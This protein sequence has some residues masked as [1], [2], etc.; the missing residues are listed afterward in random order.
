[1]RRTRAALIVLVLL[2]SL[3]AVGGQAASR[4]DSEQSATIGRFYMAD[5]SLQALHDEIE[6]DPMGIGYKNGDGTWKEDAVI[7]GLINDPANGATITRKLIER[8]EIIYSIE[9]SE[10]IQ[11]G[12]DT[13]PDGVFSDSERW[14]LS[15]AL[16]NETLDAN[17]EEVFAMLLAI[18]TTESNL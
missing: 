15:M 10:C 14:W 9:P 1:M 11:I 5:F 2:V 8:N 4:A 3:F 12:G 17:D 6:A 18:S 16:R 7:A 13:A